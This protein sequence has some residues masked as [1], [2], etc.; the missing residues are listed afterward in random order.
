MKKTKLALL[1][2]ALER[3]NTPGISDDDGLIFVSLSESF[4]RSIVG[5]YNTTNYSCTNEDCQTANNTHCNNSGCGGV[6]TNTGCANVT[7]S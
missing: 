2:D 1:L 5:G 3:D 4:S 6:I 7:C